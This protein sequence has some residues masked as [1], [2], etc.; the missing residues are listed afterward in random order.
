MIWHDLAPQLFP[1][2]VLTEYID[3]QRGIYRV[4]AFLNGRLDGAI[5][6]GPADAPPRWNEL[7]TMTGRPGIADSGSVVCA[8]FGVGIDA[9]RAA[10]VS[11]KA[12]SA[13]E[14]GIA[15]RAGTKCGSCL[16]ELR[17]MVINESHA[18]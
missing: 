3:R 15:L 16:P 8:C 4:A 17:S 10:L 9:I 7:R 1:D 11:R 12:A 6:V 2:A 14:I 18:P 13:E 5:F